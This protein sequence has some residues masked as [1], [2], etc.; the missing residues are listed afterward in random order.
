M[1]KYSKAEKNKKTNEVDRIKELAGVNED[2]IDE[3]TYEGD[4]FDTAYGDMWYNDD[5][6][7][8]QNTRDAK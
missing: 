7:T 2:F 1:D 8:K 3:E 5:S 6:L 4:D